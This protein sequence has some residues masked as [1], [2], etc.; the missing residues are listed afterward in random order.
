MY[1]NTLPDLYG[2]GLHFIWNTQH[3]PPAL[4]PMA[5]LTEKIHNN[6]GGQF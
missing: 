4:E 2:M 1:N 3:R 5:I 6:W